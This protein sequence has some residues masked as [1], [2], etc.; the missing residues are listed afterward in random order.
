MTWI[1]I[2]V[3]VVALGLAICWFALLFWMVIAAFLK[4]ISPFRRSDETHRLRW[5]NRHFGQNE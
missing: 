4:L 3:T 1:S 2:A 5:S